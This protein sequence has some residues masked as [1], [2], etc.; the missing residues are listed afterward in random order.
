MCDEVEREV[1]WGDCGDD[2]DWYSD[3]EAEFHLVVGRGVERDGFAVESLG[4]FSGPGHGLDT[5]VYFE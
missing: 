5:S 3:C 4:F 1:E 2:S